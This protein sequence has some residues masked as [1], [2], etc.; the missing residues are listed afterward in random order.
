M[1]R[2][3]VISARQTESDKRP[4]YSSRPRLRCAIHQQTPQSALS[5]ASFIERAQPARRPVRSIRAL[6]MQALACSLEAP[7]LAIA[8][9]RS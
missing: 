5:A 1:P 4:V 8:D 9:L 6:L 2:T 3:A 7:R